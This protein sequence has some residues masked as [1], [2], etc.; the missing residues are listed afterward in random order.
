[1]LSCDNSQPPLPDFLSFFCQMSLFQNVSLETGSL[2]LSP[3]LL[4][5]LLYNAGLVLRSVIF[6][7][8]GRFSNCSNL[9]APLRCYLED[10]YKHICFCRVYGTCYLQLLTCDC[11]FPGVVFF[12]LIPGERSGCEALQ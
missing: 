7:S 4:P 1:M 2:T 5:S 12:F 8:L 6:A 3:L 11:G 9:E 10:D